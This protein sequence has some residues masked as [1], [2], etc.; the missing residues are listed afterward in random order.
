M[1]THLKDKKKLANNT[2]DPLAKKWL[3]IEKK[4]K[5]NAKA[6]KKIADLYQIFTSD[7]LHE[8]KQLVELLGQETRHL[9]SFLPRK[10]FTQWQKEELSNW[11]ESNLDALSDHPFGNHE[12]TGELR[13]EY[14]DALTA[15]TKKLDEDISLDEDLFIEM[16]KLCEEVFLG[17]K[18]FS[19]DELES[20]IRDPSLFEQVFQQ[21]LEEKHAEEH[22]HED[23]FTDGFED[24]DSEQYHY[25]DQ[26]RQEEQKQESKLK[27]LFNSSNL[28]KLYKILANRLH[29]DKEKNEHLKAEKSELMAQLVKAKKNKDAYTIISMFHQF[30]PDSELSLFDGDDKEL[31]QALIK[32]L[33]EKLNEL[34]KENHEQK[35]NSSIQSMVWQKFNGR[36]KKV[37]QENIDTHLAAL[38]DG[39]AKLNYNIHEVTTVKRLK[40]ILSE[41]YEMNRFNPFANGEYSLDDLEAIFR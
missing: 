35:Y 37:T 23:F 4:Q 28:N 21:F 22:K 15:C 34:D 11:I 5:R 8:E 1:L 14:S 9:M 13:K 2:N 29:P 7:I 6:K 24:D 26:F 31:T 16:E 17:E 41:R 25:E 10:S 38:E 39:Q 12:L 40:A 30:V 36:S 32:L 20:F 27:S 19:K 3:E 18:S 33:N